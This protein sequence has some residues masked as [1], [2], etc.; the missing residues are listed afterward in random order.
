MNLSD[1]RIMK[2]AAIL[3]SNYIP[4]KGYF[5]LIASV[6]TFIWYDEVQYTKQ[7][8][9]NRNKIKTPNGIK[10]LSVPVTV[11]NLYEQ[12]ISDTLIAEPKWA[13]SHWGKLE[14]A[15]KKAPHFGAIASWLKP[16][17]LEHQY[18]HLIEINRELIT[19]ICNFLGIKTEFRCSS[20]FE[21]TDGKTERLVELCNNVNADCYVSGVAAKTYIDPNVF[22]KRKIDIS[23]FDYSDYPIYPQLWDEF[24][25]SVTILDLLFCTGAD[26][27]KYMKHVK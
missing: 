9:R 2:K 19:E 7:D 23:W 13:I 14:N 3:Q 20:E 21:I 18:S 10:W 8:W 1:N 26:A 27:S 25:H 15:Y 4:W 24:D 17:Y 11:N 5:D 6:D 22:S 16:L 12:R